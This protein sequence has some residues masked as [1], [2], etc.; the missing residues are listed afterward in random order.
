MA[1]DHGFFNRR[2]T[3]QEKEREA[4]LW[5]A[6]E[7]ISFDQRQSLEGLGLVRVQLVKPESKIPQGLL[8]LGLNESEAVDLCC[9]LLDSLRKQGAMTMPFGVDHADEAFKPRLGPIYVRS[10]KASSKILSWLPT[11]GSNRR[12]D[13]LTKIL[14]RNNSSESVEQTLDNL[15]RYMTSEDPGWLVNTLNHKMEGPLHQINYELLEVVPIKRDVL[16]KCELCAQ[17]TVININNVCVNY[18]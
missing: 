9:V 13:Y 4:G 15:W 2:A 18:R 11:K 10:K 16:Y 8:N 12:Y 3:R 17:V 14:S 5:I 6:Q 1:T 7:L